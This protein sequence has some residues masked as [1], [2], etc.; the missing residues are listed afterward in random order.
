MRLPHKRRRLA[1]QHESLRLG[2]EEKLEQANEASLAAEQ[3]LL[4]GKPLDCAE[5][6]RFQELAREGDEA[7][8]AYT[9]ERGAAI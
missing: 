3:A 8:L 1:S 4:A 7:L 2:A 9:R 6:R 5:V